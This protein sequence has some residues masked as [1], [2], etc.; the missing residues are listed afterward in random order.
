[1]N[2]LAILALSLAACTS[3]MDGGPDAGPGG[4]STA[5][6]E[7]LTC[8]T[9]SYASGTPTNGT[10]TEVS[11]ALVDGVDPASG[12]VIEQCDAASTSNGVATGAGGFCPAG[13]TCTG[14]TLP[15]YAHLCERSTAGTFIDGALYVQCGT[16]STTMSGGAVT[17]SFSTQYATVQLHR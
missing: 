4:T 15:S 10:T 9:Y 8:K 1:M 5:G 3:A 11:Y 6:F 16:K 17:S 2:R 13:D 14:A 12:F 7:V